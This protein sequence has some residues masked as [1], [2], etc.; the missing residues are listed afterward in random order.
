EI[1]NDTYSSYKLQTSI[2]QTE[3]ILIEPILIDRD[4][5][6]I[7]RLWDNITNLSSFYIDL[8]I[9]LIYIQ[10]SIDIATVIPQEIDAYI[11]IEEHYSTLNF[12][13]L[14]IQNQSEY[15]FIY[16]NLIKEEHFFLKRM[17]NTQVELHFN[18]LQEYSQQ[19]NH[20]LLHYQIDLTAIALNQPI[21]EIKFST[22]TIFHLPKHI[23]SQLKSHF[24]DINLWPIDREMLERSL[25]VIINLNSQST[26]EQFIIASLRPIREHLAE[27][28][29]VNIN[30]VHI[31]TFDLKA[32]HQIELLIAIIRYPSRLRPPR[33]IHKKLLYNAL[34]NST[35]LFVKI[36]H[37]KSIEK[38]LINQCDLQSCENNGRCTSQ[39]KLLNNQYEYFYYERYQRLLPK[40]QWNIKCLCLNHYYGQ[41]CQHKQHY[42]SP[43]TSNPCSPLE[44]CIEESATL[45]TCQCIDEP[46]N[47]NEVLLENTLDC[48]NINSPT[49]RGMCFIKIRITFDF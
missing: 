44:R 19:Q 32:Q 15:K 36:L 37:I 43:C 23:N 10:R 18:S 21:P 31:Y 6:F 42:E 12:G 5:N 4:D 13:P 33:Y 1:L 29:G 35:H 22:K 45:Y 14:F 9:R 38:I 39:I 25:S 11:N 16:Y 48:I 46:C 41:R 2:N 28:I 30:H 8:H 40:Y 3:L 7:I 26:Y 24:I 47:Y 34:K 17:S 20:R 27:I 49:C